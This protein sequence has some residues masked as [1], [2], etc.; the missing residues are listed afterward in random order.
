MERCSGRRD[1]CAALEW[2]VVPTPWPGTNG[3]TYGL[4]S[5]TGSAASPPGRTRRRR[6]RPRWR[7]LS[8]PAAPPDAGLG[9]IPTT[10][11]CPR[12]VGGAHT[13][14]PSS[15]AAGRPRPWRSGDS[16]G[17]LD[18]HISPSFSTSN[19]SVSEL[20]R[21]CTPSIS[22]T[23]EAGRFFAF[24]GLPSAAVDAHLT[25]QFTGPTVG[26][27]R[28]LQLDPGPGRSRRTSLPEGQ[29]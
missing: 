20:A 16:G 27:H 5:Q 9:N 23:P 3:L 29:C 21:S 2:Y 19:V 4:W 6:N 15:A 1:R 25:L 11:R 10:R 12:A 14:P 17:P 18:S 24:P 26:S 8:G 7:S 28:L 22:K 13:S